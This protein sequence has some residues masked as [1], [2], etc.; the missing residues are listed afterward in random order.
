MFDNQ[1]E[2]FL[3]TTHVATHEVYHMPSIHFDTLSYCK[4]LK[5]VGVTEAVAEVHA[6]ALAE[7]I[8]KNLAT[9]H[10]IWLVRKE[11]KELEK[12]IEDTRSELK[13]DIHEIG[14]KLTIRMGSM[15]TAAILLLPVIFKIYTYFIKI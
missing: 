6:E 11:I 9:K 14:S 10:D 8:D 15:M 5:A 1:K 12:K 13:R 7:V 4:K 2:T 3:M